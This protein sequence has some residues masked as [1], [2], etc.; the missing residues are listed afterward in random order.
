MINIKCLIKGHNWKFSYNHGIPLG[1][2]EKQWDI[3]IKNSYQVFECTICPEQGRLIDDSIRP[4]KG[5]YN[6]RDIVVLNK[7]SRETP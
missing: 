2:S 3:L 1:C 5:E 6:H 4:I 7:W